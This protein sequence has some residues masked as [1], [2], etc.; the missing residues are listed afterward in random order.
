MN[1]VR[2]CA[3]C[4]AHFRPID[5][6]HA[7]CDTCIRGHVVVCASRLADIASRKDRPLPVS[8]IR[9]IAES[10]VHATNQSRFEPEVRAVTASGSR[11]P[12]GRAPITTTSRAER[13]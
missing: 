10:I 6:S 7:H 12:L 2:C 5:A 13:H 4:G 11:H 1:A 3:T 9:S 8:E